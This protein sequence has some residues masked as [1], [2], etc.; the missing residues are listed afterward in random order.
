[1][2]KLPFSSNKVSLCVLLKNQ[3]GEG[4]IVPEP[5]YFHVKA[6][7]RFSTSF[8]CLFTVL[9]VLPPSWLLLILKDK[10]T[11]VIIEK[12]LLIK[13]QSWDAQSIEWEMHLSP[14]SPSQR[15]LLVCFLPQIFLQCQ[16][17]SQHLY[18]LI[19]NLAFWVLTDPV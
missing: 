19:L 15:F 5:L 13:I 4:K 9:I 8:C 12:K 6:E 10:W 16:C 17:V 14:Q 18:F 7:W 3:E 11:L 2:W 1:M